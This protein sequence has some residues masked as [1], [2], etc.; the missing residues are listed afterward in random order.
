[1]RP[2]PVEGFL[3][4]P[5]LNNPGPHRM[6][7]MF[8]PETDAIGPTM[9]VE[10]RG[11]GATEWTSVVAAAEQPP[12]NDAV[13]VAFPPGGSTLSIYRAELTGL[14][15]NTV[16]EYRVVT[17]A[18]TTPTAIFKTWP[19]PEDGVERGR[20]IAFSDIQG[21]HIAE[22]WFPRVLQ[23]IIDNE[24]DGDLSACVHNIAGLV[25]PGD[26]VNRGSDIDDWRDEYFAPGDALFRYLPQIPAMGNHDVPM[27]NY[28]YYFAP[29]SN[30][31]PGFEEEWY[32]LDFL[33]LRLLTLQSNFT[34]AR[35]GE[36]YLHQ[37]TFVAEQLA[38]ADRDGIDYVFA[39]VHAP[40]KSELWLPGESPQVCE[41]VRMLEDWSARTGK[42]SGHLYGHTHAYSRGQSRD[43]S[44]LWLNVASAAGNIDDWGDY[45][46]ADYDEMEM[47][48]DE[49]GYVRF[50]FSTTGTPEVA[51]VRHTGG[52]DHGNHPDAFTQ[53]AIRDDIVI[54]GDNDPPL[55]PE[56]MSPKNGT[57]VETADAVLHALFRDTTGGDLLEAHWQVRP[58]GGTYDAPLFDVWGSETR[59][60]NVWFREDLNAGIQNDHWRV[61]YLDAGDYCWRTRFRDEHWA[62]SEWSEDTCF[63]VAGTTTSDN[64]LTNG[65]AEAGTEGWEVLDGGLQAVSGSECSMSD[66][67][68]ISFTPVR[69]LVPYKGAR[70]FSVG[71]CSGTVAARARV[72]QMLDVSEYAEEIDGGR[73]LGVLEA[74]VRTYSKWDVATVQYRALD[75]S[76]AELDASTPLVNQTGTWVRRPTSALLPP[77]TRSVEVILSGLRQHGSSNDSF[78]DDVSFRVVTSPQARGPFTEP[79]FSPGNGMG[80]VGGKGWVFPRPHP[81]RNETV[82]P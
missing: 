66:N 17:G 77:G 44:H 73:T 74:A 32:S 76:G 19:T 59:A 40:C 75:A 70:F 72:S 64:L 62:W 46:M 68:E 51:I 31:S 36:R 39:S 52:D 20:L 24:C 38:G 5:Y 81:R 63:T 8:E 53:N 65:D 41:Y 54:G 4:A 14:I 9:A 82:Q 50:D 61:P 10:Y 33:N 55:R 35:L 67:A 23:A 47:S 25:I 80:V 26:L 60:H 15:S 12:V 18:G 3:V 37:S 56:V 2:E 30:G 28:L 29:P 71:G 58:E 69:Q 13:V 48:W 11:Q 34:G 45:E 43:V 27:G 6:T 79:I 57:T 42:I 21:N 1:M 78:V 49:Y 22:E 16:Y 7:I